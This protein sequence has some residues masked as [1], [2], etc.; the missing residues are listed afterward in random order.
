MPLSLEGPIELKLNPD[1]HDPKKRYFKLYLD[2]R[3]VIRGRQLL[4]FNIPR[5][6]QMR[7]GLEIAVQI[8]P[9][10]RRR[11]W[12]DTAPPLPDKY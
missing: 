7:S 9:T 5:W 10:K 2:G 11:S 6:P 12:L 1:N 3:L 8:D 4:S